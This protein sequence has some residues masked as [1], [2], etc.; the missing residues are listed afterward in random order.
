MDYAEHPIPPALDGLVTA[1]WSLRGI[2]GPDDRITHAATPDGCVE[3]IR[4]LDGRSWWDGE[5]PERFVTGLAEA[6]I[7]FAMS[8]D[9]AFAGIRM[10][11][12]TWA[13]LGGPAAP[14]FAGRWM[15]LDPTNAAHAVLDDP[16]ALGPRLA[17]AIAE[18]DAGPIARAIP[19]AASVADIVAASGQSHRTLQRWFAAIIG[20]PPRRYV[21]LARFRAALIDLAD[22]PATLAEHASATGF[23]DQAHMARD[24]RSLAG[25]PP[26]E[27]RKR[28]VGPFLPGDER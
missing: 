3:L 27:V 7:E 10:W 24:F 21:R 5:Q 11:P 12:W 22:P 16:A 17:A 1:I 6:P 4:R 18:R 2:G 25:V 14:A 9:A 23:A 13:M 28:A 20:L 8:G 15:P 19:D 26:R